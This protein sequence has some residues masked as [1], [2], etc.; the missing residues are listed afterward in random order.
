MLYEGLDLAA[1]VLTAG[2]IGYRLVAAVR[3]V[4]MLRA[5]VTIRED[6]SPEELAFLAGG[7]RRTAATVLFRMV[8]QGRLLLA[9]DGTVTVT[10]G[11]YTGGSAAGIEEALVEAAGISRSERVGKLV[12]RTA[13]SRAVRAVGDRLQEEGLLLRTALRR[14]QYRARRLLWW[15]AALALVPAVWAPTTGTADHRW[16]G[17]VLAAG[18]A[19]TATLVKPSPAWVPY[20]VQSTLAILRGERERPAPWRRT[21]ALAALA[22]TPVGAVALGGLSAAPE[23]EFRE[24]V[25]PETWRAGDPAF[26]GASDTGL[27]T[28]GHRGSCGYAAACGGG[29]GGGCG[30]AGE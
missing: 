2:A 21:G 13:A 26:G 3:I 8:R 4:V 7:P 29:D 18:A 5:E 23:P 27:G 19:L 30:G 11:A 17:V 25:T 9:E 24:L 15:S 1:L 22:V 14:G 6:L 12:A 16:A 10:D 28:S 20:R